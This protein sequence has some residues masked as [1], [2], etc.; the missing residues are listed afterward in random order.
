MN[1]QAVEFSAPDRLNFP[2]KASAMLM[3]GFA[4]NLMSFRGSEK[5][6]SFMPVR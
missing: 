3:G 6:F 2:E 4:E 5:A 1:V